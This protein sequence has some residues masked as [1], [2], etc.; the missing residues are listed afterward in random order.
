MPND[1]YWSDRYQNA[2]TGW[3]LGSVSPALKAYFDQ[4]QRKNISVLIPGCG[5]AHEAEYL[6]AIG[7]TD[8]TLIDISEVLV[9][10]LQEKL[11]KYIENGHCKV[12]H[13]DFFDHSGSYDLIIEQTFF[14]AIDPSLREQYAKKMSELLKPK[15]ILVGLLFDYDFVGGPPFGGTKEEYKTYFE[16][17]FRF[18]FFEK[19]TNSIAPRVGNELFICLKTK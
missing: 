5:N 15:A 16:P 12:I 3:D 19:C 1:K 4:L 13:Q 11:K 17:Y 6:L 10:N 14:C 8:V 2:Q 18:K 7:F 9:R